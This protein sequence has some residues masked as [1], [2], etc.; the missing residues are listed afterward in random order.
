MKKRKT[1]EEFAKEI[2]ELTDGL[3]QLEGSYKNKET[4]TQVKG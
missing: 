3:F 2:Q 4:I 1:T